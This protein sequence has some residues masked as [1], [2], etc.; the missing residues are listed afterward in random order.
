MNTKLT[1]PKDRVGVRKAGMSC[2]PANVLAEV[3]V[4]MTEGALKYGAYNFRAA[5]VRSSVYYDGTLRHLMAWWEGED[6]DKDSGLSHVTKAIASLVVLRD[7]MLHDL[8]T[9]DRPPRT[10]G[11]YEAL[12]VKADALITRYG[13]RQPQHYTHEFVTA[14]QE[15]PK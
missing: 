7:A 2:V 10:E 3:G 12:N 15:T 9:D 5:G 11:F 14:Q 6:I 13:D 1:N 4:A 8:V